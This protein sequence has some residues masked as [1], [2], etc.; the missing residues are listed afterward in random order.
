MASVQSRGLIEQVREANV[1][2]DWDVLSLPIGRA[3]VGLPAQEPFLFQFK[4]YGL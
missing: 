3:I 1:V 2:E 4:L